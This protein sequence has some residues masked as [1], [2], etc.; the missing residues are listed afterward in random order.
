MN[1]VD[2]AGAFRLG[3]TRT[4]LAMLPTW[5]PQ[6]G[7][8]T[9]LWNCDCDE[10]L[11][12]GAAGGGKSSA[13]VAMLT[14][15]IHRP[16]YRGLVL[17]RTST[18]LSHLF[19]EARSI[20]HDGRPYGRSAFKAF[21]PAPESR[22]FDTFWLIHQKGGRAK[23]GHC[24][25]DD[26]Y[27]GHMGLQW[28]DIFFDE[29]PHYTR[30]QYTSLITRRRGTIPGIR[31]R[32]ISTANPPEPG[33]PG[34]EWVK[35]RWAPW[36]DE[37]CE[38]KDWEQRDPKS[39]E[40]V[41]GFGLP[42]R[43]V[44]GKRVPPA[45]SGQ[46]LYVADVDGIERFSTEPF[47]WR[48]ARAPTR[49]FIQSKLSDNPA[50]LEAEPD[51]AAKL[52]LVDPVRAQQLE[53]GDWTIKPAAGLYF[54]RGWFELV[55]EVPPGKATWVRHWDLAATMPTKDNPDP[56]WTRAPRMCLHEDG[57]FYWDDL[58]SCR[59]D[60]GGTDALIERTIAEDDGAGVLQSFAQEPGS[61]GKNDAVRLVNLAHEIGQ[62]TSQDIAATYQRE[63]GAK[64]LRI[65]HVSSLASPKSTGGVYGKIRIVR[66]SWNRQ[67]FQELEGW[68]PEMVQKDG[69]DDIPDAM[70]GCIRVLESG[71]G[72]ASVD[73]TIIGG[74]RA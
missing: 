17:R 57:F 53:E 31:R 74:G 18:D 41:R 29:L 3:L 42:A 13:I 25:N 28:D 20:F 71:T 66:G 37:E 51:Y 54:K 64:P 35:P 39:G 40:M 38:L 21:A 70:A 47:S 34:A 19:D 73:V 49:T 6:A 23:F 48:G 12:G 56:D 7:P 4:V 72:A 50:M 2:A 44:D 14:Q 5:T 9:E 69:H 43:E 27:R 46:M 26:D 62:R 45:R 22:F 32:A 67:A 36:L 52:R 65:R 68:F 1:L 8:Q 16:G 15:R 61:A 33:E 30:R 11:Y 55:D 60:P 58:V 59:E 63:S 10:I 24:H